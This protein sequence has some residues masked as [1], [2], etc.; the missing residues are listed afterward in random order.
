MSASPPPLWRSPR[1]GRVRRV[2][3]DHDGQVLDQQQH[4]GR[5]QRHRLEPRPAGK[6]SSV[7]SYASSVLGRHRG[8]KSKDTG[9]PVKPA[10]R[11]VRVG[12][13]KSAD[14]GLEAGTEVFTGKARLDTTAYS[15]NLG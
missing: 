13:T 2:R 4:V 8:W 6:S 10:D 1:G 5:R 14:F 11:I 9:P 12:N 3:V 7:K 15:T